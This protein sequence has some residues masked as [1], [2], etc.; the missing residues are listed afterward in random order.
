[1]TEKSKQPTANRKTRRPMSRADIENCL[2][3][4]PEL[5]QAAD[6]EVGCSY[7]PTAGELSIQG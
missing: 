5:Q 1:M 7:D 3:R 2:R 4:H 6:E